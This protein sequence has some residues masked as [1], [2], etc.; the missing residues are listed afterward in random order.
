LPSTDTILRNRLE[1]VDRLSEAHAHFTAAVEAGTGSGQP[2]KQALNGL[3]LALMELGRAAEGVPLLRQA[4]AQDPLWRPATVN[5]GRCLA[6]AG[7]TEEGLAL[8]A[9]GVK[10]KRPDG[11]LAENLEYSAALLRHDPANEWPVA[12]RHMRVSMEADH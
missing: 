11:S 3:A 10:K 12:V 6:E 8:L 4:V 1:E 9:K 5:L 7:E 2:L